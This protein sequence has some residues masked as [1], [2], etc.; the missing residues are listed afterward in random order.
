[1]KQ[2]SE[3]RTNWLEFM[4]KHTNGDPY[5]RRS[6]L[7]AGLCKRCIFWNSDS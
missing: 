5:G 4:R 7:L 6:E 3:S 2:V 1:M